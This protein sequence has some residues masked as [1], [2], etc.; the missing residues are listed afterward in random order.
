MVGRENF[1]YTPSVQLIYSVQ[2]K[3]IL[4]K[5]I[6]AK[7]EQICSFIT[8]HFFMVLLHKKTQLH[9]WY[10]SIFSLNAGKMDQK[11]SEYGH[12]SRSVTLYLTLQNM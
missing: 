4:I 2:K 12:F 3:K 9:L 11:I 10:L 8:F 7:D 5:D 6:Y 1:Q